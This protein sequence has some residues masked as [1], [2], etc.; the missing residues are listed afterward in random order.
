M[1]WADSPAC[2]PRSN[3]PAARV[4]TAYP[5][6]YGTLFVP[7][8]DGRLVALAEGGCGAATCSPQCR[9]ARRPGPADLADV[10]YPRGPAEHPE[11]VAGPGD[12]FPTPPRCLD[13]T[14]LPDHSRLVTR[15]RAAV[16][17]Q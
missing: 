13:G 12:P 14:R 6:A 8:A 3:A 17:S 16:L 7:T 5:L 4:P 11:Q 15:V 1:S 9:S 10:P 2:C